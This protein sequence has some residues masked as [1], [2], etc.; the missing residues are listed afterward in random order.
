MREPSRQN[1]MPPGRNTLHNPSAS[2]V[3]DRIA[4]H[5]IGEPSREIHCFDS[6]YLEI[7]IGKLWSKHCSQVPHVLHSVRVGVQSEDFTALAQQVD[8]VAPIPT[9]SVEHAHSR[10]DISAQNLIEHIDIDLPELLLKTKRRPFLLRHEAFP[11]TFRLNR[12]T[13]FGGTSVVTSPPNWKTP[14]TSRELT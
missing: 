8:Q 12:S 10:R 5:H 2:K 3:Q 13:T 4:D 14:L 9:S 7:P 11:G 6:A 1:N